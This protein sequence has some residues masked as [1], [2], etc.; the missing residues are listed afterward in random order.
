MGTTR[1]MYVFVI[2]V[3]FCNFPGRCSTGCF[4]G[5][6]FRTSDSQNK[7]RSD[8]ACIA[9][10]YKEAGNNQAVGENYGIIKSMFIARLG[11]EPEESTMNKFIK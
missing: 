5:V 11:N 8:N 7:F 1:Y 10:E 4:L 3:R 2:F 9:E 6:L